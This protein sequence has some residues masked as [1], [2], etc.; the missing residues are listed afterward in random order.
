[1]Y[2]ITIAE[3]MYLYPHANHESFNQ[4][5]IVACNEMRRGATKSTYMRLFVA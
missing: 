5:D 4:A 3:Q 1:M 2:G